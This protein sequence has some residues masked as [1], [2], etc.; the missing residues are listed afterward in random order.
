MKLKFNFTYWNF[1]LEAFIITSK[2]P[3]KTVI[4][5]ISN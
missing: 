4:H 5:L 3:V 1:Q 2:N